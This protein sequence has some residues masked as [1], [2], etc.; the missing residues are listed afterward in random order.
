MGVLITAAIWFGE[1]LLVLFF[2][3]IAAII[4]GTISIICILAAPTIGCIAGANYGEKWT[5]T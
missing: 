1:A 3:G 2:G 5:V 4:V